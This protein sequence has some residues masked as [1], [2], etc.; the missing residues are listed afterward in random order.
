MKAIHQVSILHM[1]MHM[2]FIHNRNGY[3]WMDDFP[4]RISVYEVFFF[5]RISPLQ[6][7]FRTK[8]PILMVL[9]IKYSINLC[10]IN[11]VMNRH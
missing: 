1:H 2:S 11:F 7:A 4:F 10:T 9:S 6:F 5:I 8:R 3:G